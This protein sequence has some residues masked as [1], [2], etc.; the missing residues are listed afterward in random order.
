MQYIY[1]L[2]IVYKYNYKANII[3]LI[4]NNRSLLLAKEV[5]I[6]TSRLREFRSSGTKVSPLTALLIC[7]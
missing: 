6:N 7:H 1:V 2:I 5:S 3:K 4:C